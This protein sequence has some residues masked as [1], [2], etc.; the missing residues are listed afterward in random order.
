MD[1]TTGLEFVTADRFTST[2]HIVT[3]TSNLHRPVARRL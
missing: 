3:A 2:K 1:Q